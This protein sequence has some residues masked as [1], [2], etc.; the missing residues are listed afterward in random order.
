[1]I[2]SRTKI[3]A[4]QSG[5]LPDCRT[6][7][8]CPG[9]TSSPPSPSCRHR[10]LWQTGLFEYWWSWTIATVLIS[11]VS[12]WHLHCF[13]VFVVCRYWVNGIALSECNFLVY[14]INRVLCLDDCNEQSCPWAGYDPSNLLPFSRTTFGSYIYYGAHGFSKKRSY[15]ANQ[16]WIVL[17]TQSYHSLKLLCV[18]F[19]TETTKFWPVHQKK[20]QRRHESI[21]ALG[22]LTTYVVLKWA[23]PVVCI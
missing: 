19:G 20:G 15:F 10:T 22:S 4:I 2:L 14:F 5:P 23:I 17:A 7:V 6:P 16:T 8:I 3:Y 13:S 1:M 18:R 21:T 9:F 11:S 12:A